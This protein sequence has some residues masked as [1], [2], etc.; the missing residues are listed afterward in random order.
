MS[1]LFQVI[2][3]HPLIQSFSPVI[4]K[5]TIGL[6]AQTSGDVTTFEHGLIVEGSF[7]VLTYCFMCNHCG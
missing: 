4:H 2:V 7:V 3:G 6:T 5:A 1:S